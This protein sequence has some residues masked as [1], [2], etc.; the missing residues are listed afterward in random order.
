MQSARTGNKGENG[1]AEGRVPLHTLHLR[2]Q[3]LL[4][5]CIFLLTSLG[6]AEFSGKLYRAADQTSK[7]WGHAQSPSRASHSPP[8]HA[9]S[10]PSSTIGS[11]A[12]K[13]PRLKPAR[14]NQS[15]FPTLDD[16]LGLDRR[17]VAETFGAPHATERNGASIIWN[18]HIHHCRMQ[19][20]FYPDIERRTFHALQYALTDGQ[21]DQPANPKPCFNSTKPQAGNDVRKIRSN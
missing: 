13:T 5:A 15:D 3:P 4:A 12:I 2:H 20:V 7:N 8:K 17:A 11:F 16:I 21:G 9:Q 19:I 10:R 6:C 18:Y 14:L 1:R